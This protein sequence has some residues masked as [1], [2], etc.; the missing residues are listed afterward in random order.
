M[1]VDNGTPWGGSA[2][3]RWTRLGVWLLKHGVELLHSRPYHP[4]SRGK[5][6]RLHRT[7]KAEVLAFKTLRDF[8]EAQRSFDEWRSIYNLERP[9]Q[10]IEM[11]VPI[12]RYRPSSRAMPDR[13]PQVEYDEHEI[14]RTVPATKDY[15]SFKGRRWKV[16]QAFRTERVAIRPLTTDGRF[17]V[18]F[19]SHQIATI[20]LTN[21]KCVGDVSEQ[22]S[23]M[24]PD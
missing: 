15:I 14:V 12:R 17:G 22:V 24:F 5:N 7:L 3:A 23:D 13:P 19:A 10:A 21:N 1:F 6:E 9:H 4:Q 18:F 20:D 11:E 2:A 16:P 8:V